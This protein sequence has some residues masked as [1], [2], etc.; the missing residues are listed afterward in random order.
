MKLFS[1]FLS[2]LW[3][4]SLVSMSCTVNVSSFIGTPTIVRPSAVDRGHR[5]VFQR[6]SLAEGHGSGV[7]CRRL[8]DGLDQVGARR[9]EPTVVSSGPRRPPRPLTMW[10]DEQRPLPKNSVSPRAASPVA[11]AA[12]AAACAGR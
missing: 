2:K 8:A 12:A 6:A 11:A 3:M 5:V 1:D 10:Q 9:A 4:R 7:R